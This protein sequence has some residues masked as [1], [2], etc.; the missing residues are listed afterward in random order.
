MEDD[1]LLAPEPRPFFVE[2]GLKILGYCI[3][4]GGPCYGSGS[5]IHTEAC[6]QFREQFEALRALQIVE[7]TLWDGKVVIRC[8]LCA[9]A[10]YKGASECHLDGCV[11]APFKRKDV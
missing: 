4:C 5:Q 9:G 10:W 6:A 11:A 8:S 3:L 1:S 7:H 2:L